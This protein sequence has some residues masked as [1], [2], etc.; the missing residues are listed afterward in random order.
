LATIAERATTSAE[1]DHSDGVMADAKALTEHGT[2][3]R[4]CIAVA[5]RER[6]LGDL[7]RLPPAR[8]DRGR[9]L[10]SVTRQFLDTAHWNQAIALG[11]GPIEFFGFNPHAA[12]DRLDAQGLVT[13]LALSNVSMSRLDAIT[14]AAATI[15]DRFG[16]LFI[17]RRGDHGCDVE[18]LWWR[19]PA[20]I[21]GAENFWLKDTHADEADAGA[22]RAPSADH[23]EAAA[24]KRADHLG[25]CRGATD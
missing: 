7:A 2:P 5:Y 9:R 6:I 11:W 21:G 19:C 20:L 3:S 23:H 18:E 17:Y 16:S 22:L 25:G 14:E 8:D 15:R 24:E 10:L 12:A 13:G 1:A 4:R